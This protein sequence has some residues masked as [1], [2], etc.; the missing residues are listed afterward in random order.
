MKTV[1]A[2]DVRKNFGRILDEAA[3]GERMIIER[4]GQPRA[5]LVP[6]E[7]LDR[8]DP[9]KQLAE[10]RAALDDLIRRARRRPMPPD[11][12]AARIV[13]E[14]RDEREAH[15]AAVI[16]ENRRRDT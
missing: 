5:I 3:A 14:M 13:R 15:I 11:F 12:D 8:V 10:K 9:E 1:S 16:A 7:D 2:L 4:A 6:M